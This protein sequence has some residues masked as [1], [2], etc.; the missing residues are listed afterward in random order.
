M[1]A[2]DQVIKSFEFAKDVATHLITLGTAVIGVSLTF[3]KD[4]IR[5]VSTRLRIVLCLSWVFCLLSIAGGA[6]VLMSLAGELSRAAQP[7]IYQ[8][9][10]RFCAILQIVFFGLA[11]VF[12][13]IFAFAAAAEKEQHAA[14]DG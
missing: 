6:F 13:L 14:L 4:V 5:R 11:I 9:G 10:I 2:P 8:S 12:S 1:V 3:A 7:T